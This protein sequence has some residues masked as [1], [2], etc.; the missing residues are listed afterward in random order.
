M[1]VT[2]IATVILLPLM[3]YFLLSTK[4]VQKFVGD[5]AQRELSVLLGADVKIGRVSITP[6]TNLALEQVSVTGEDGDTLLVADRVGAGILPGKLIFK[7]R[8][9][10]SYAEILGLDLR[11]SRD[12]ASGPLNI[13]P[14]L[15]HL[16]PGDTGR[17]PKSFD[18][19]IK[20]V[21]IRN[22]R[23]SYD[24]LSVPVTESFS[25]SHVRISGLRADL[26]IPLLKNDGY[27]VI[28]RRLAMKERSGLDI[29]SL[30]GEFV[31]T[32][33][34]MSVS[35][36]RLRLPASELMLAPMT[37]PLDGLADLGPQLFSAPIELRTLPGSRL[38]PADFS[39]FLPALASEQ[40]PLRVTIDAAG[41]LADLTVSDF[42]IGGSDTPL[43][44]ALNGT[45]AGLPIADS[46]QVNLPTV[47]VQATS[48]LMLTLLEGLTV[49][50]DKNRRL[51]AG[52]EAVDF[53]GSIAGTLRGAET[54]GRL[55]TAYGSADLSAKVSHQP[56]GL[57]HMTASLQTDSLQIGRILDR[58]DLGLISAAIDA[59]VTLRH[60]RLTAGKATVALP[61]LVYNQLPL[62]D[63]RADASLH[64]DTMRLNL[65]SGSPYIGADLTASVARPRRGEHSYL[66]KGKINSFR[67]ASL[68]LTDRFPGYTLSAA[69]DI[70][71]HG[72]SPET[73]HGKAQINNIAF[74]DS[75]GSGVR[76]N[77]IQL[78][79]GETDTQRMLQFHSDFASGTMTGRYTYAR[80]LPALRSLVAEALPSLLPPLPA[81]DRRRTAPPEPMSFDVRMAV[82]DNDATRSLM[83]FFNLPLE[84]FRPVELRGRFSEADR[85][86]NLYIQ[87]P[88]L[89]KGDKFIDSTY[90]ALTIDGGQALLTASTIL[91]TKKGPLSLLFSS[92]AEAD[93]ISTKVTWDIDNPRRFD[94]RVDIKSVL[95]RTE[96]GGSLAADISFARSTMAFNDTAWVVQP[97]TVTVADRYVKVND[98]EISR[99]GQYV[100]IDGNVSAS[101]TDSLVVRLLDINLDYVFDALAIPNVSFGGVA[102]GDFY[103]WGL[104]GPQP[105]LL[106]PG[107][108]VNSIKYNHTV[109]GDAE[110]TSRWENDTKGIHILADIYQPNDKTS[111]IDGVIYPL[112]EALDFSFKANSIDVAFLK[113][114]M[115]AF[116]SEVTG[117]ASGDARLYGTFKYIDLTGD[118]LAE[119]VGLK[120]DFTNTTYTTTHRV[121]IEPGRIDINGATLHDRNGHTAALDGYVTHEFFK[122]PQFRFDVRPGSDFLCYD[123]PKEKS[124]I[125]YGQVYGH[126]TFNVNSN[127]PRNNLPPTIDINANITTDRQT[128]FNF[129][130]NDTRSAVDYDFI[131]FFDRNAVNEELILSLEDPS[132]L[133]R[134]QR[135]DS[136]AESKREND[137]GSVYRMNL[138]ANATP[139][140]EMVIVM[141]PKENDQIKAHGTGTIDLSYDSGTDRL[142]MR[143]RYEL[144]Q[145]TYRVTIQGIV[146][147]DFTIERGSSISFTGDP[148]NANL[149][150]T[151][152]K[153]VNS[154]NLG[155]LD[156]SFLQ[157]P[158]INKPT[159]PV[160]AIVT[161][162]GPMT[163]PTLGFD[164]RFPTATNDDIYRKVRSIVS[165]DELMQSQILYLLAFE[166]YYTPEYMG[167]TSH[168]NEL[169]S[170]ASSTISS[171]IASALGELSDNWRIA[172]SFRS[173]RGDFSDMEVDLALS[174]YLLDNRL[175]FNGN[176]GYRDS[177]LSNNT[178]VGDFDLEYLLNKSGNLRL[179]AYNRYNDQNYYLRSA[180]TTQGVGV[181]FKRD[182]DNIFSFWHRLFN[183][184]KKS[185]KSD[186]TAR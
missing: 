145:G 83:H 49:I 142:E 79:P 141:D 122:N 111:K 168:G 179:K 110:I 30:S 34:L 7:R 126:G 45:V 92:T 116:T 171:R 115:E 80:I 167:A 121:K 57:L 10:V 11:I 28:M 107:L 174:S 94:G 50:S 37:L 182:F 152:Y 29:Q 61:L 132:A 166:R 185:D 39:C 144:E 60:N 40:W 153:H 27:S 63:I 143:G 96:P 119:N 130:I 85:F 70:D 68:A 106:T 65:H 137:V 155:D 66:L 2:A 90:T 113:P 33:S 18:L 134:K 99:E 109:L 128:V 35:K 102:T 98:M 161:A 56:E 53:R 163:A 149:D 78:T 147:N 176:F 165:T 117:H 64:A 127:P 158:E 44:L 97:A 72:T 183:R 51:I 19:Q 154:A 159:M 76:L 148:Y 24:V 32:D 22:G 6:F 114:Y 4:E 9:V 88:E 59:D 140:A 181:I 186:D 112:S 104:L 1:V 156:E 52:A 180:L 150:I 135:A 38:T 139:Q 151:A 36:F 87:A 41:T 170:M 73:L 108:T 17:P 71:L 136:I 69:V 16:R 21:V 123:M 177:A 160:D 77:L 100:K 42:A 75:A 131:T 62:T 3:L 67:P 93:R 86:A 25:P 173:E 48:P 84:I 82:N 5:V 47:S 81:R 184:R 58:R 89:L 172:P 157:D 20:N 124:P 12:S 74:T 95:S 164:L 26:Y 23:A 125:W 175:L 105:R 31:L 146:T 178:F 54:S 15:D 43:S 133:R 103:A 162:S 118:I 55:A 169:V 138:V 129:E 120:L 91:P 8:V 46:L 14:I 101:E 13:Q